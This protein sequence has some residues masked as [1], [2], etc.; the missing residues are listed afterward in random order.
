MFRPLPYRCFVG[1]LVISSL[2]FTFL[3]GVP[4]PAAIAGNNLRPRIVD[5][6]IPYGEQRRTQMARYSRRHYGHATWRLRDP[7]IIVLHFTAG[8]SYA[9]AR[10]WFA[11]NT[12]NRGEYP[13]VCAQFLIGKGGKT[14]ELVRPRIRCRHA[15]G[16][17]HRAI[18]VEMVQ[19][20]GKGSHW[21][22]RQILQRPKQVRPALRLVRYLKLR[23][24]IRMRNIIGHA[25]TNN[26]PFFRDLMGWRSD[27]T[28]W[29]WREVR[30]FR[31]R[32]K[33]ML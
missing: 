27:H 11:S 3:I 25:M 26:S 29:M 15:I 16:L 19:E 7:R 20:A 17:N 31:R 4:S 8:D 5:D 2:A 13:G 6:H 12:P 24:D 23:F 10:G 21:A 18:G 9:G 14:G 1:W 30:E 33:R 28:D 32:L 22:S